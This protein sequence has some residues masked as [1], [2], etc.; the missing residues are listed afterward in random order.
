MPSESQQRRTQRD[1]ER[2]ARIETERSRKKQ[3]DAQPIEERDE[4]SQQIADLAA[5]WG[6]KR[7]AQ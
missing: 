5:T 7:K 2:I 4:L 1:Q 6:L 3:E